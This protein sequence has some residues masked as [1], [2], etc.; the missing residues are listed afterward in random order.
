MQPRLN[1]SDDILA[2]SA[3]LPR[4]LMPTVVIFGVHAARLYHAAYPH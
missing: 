3:F 4:E 1:Q 2:T